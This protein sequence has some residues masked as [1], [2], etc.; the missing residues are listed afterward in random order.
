M[1]ESEGFRLSRFH[2]WYNESKFFKWNILD[3]NIVTLDGQT[4]PVRNQ[5]KYVDSTSKGDG[6]I[7]NDVNNRVQTDRYLEHNEFYVT[8]IFRYKAEGKVLSSCY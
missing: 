6:E 1:L 2:T 4:I 8:A 3:Y 7:D 5:F